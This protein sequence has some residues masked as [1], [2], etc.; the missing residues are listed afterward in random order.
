M[1][2]L[3]NQF[4]VLEPGVTSEKVWLNRA[5]PPA[6]GGLVGCNMNSPVKGVFKDG[7]AFLDNRG[8]PSDIAR[9][10]QGAGPLPDRG[11]VDDATLVRHLAPIRQARVWL[12]GPTPPGITDLRIHRVMATGGT[13]ATVE[14]R[15]GK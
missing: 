6:R 14:I 15:A 1:L 2:A 7:F 5:V 10:P 4:W 3:N 13:E 9:S 8:D 12:P 11:G